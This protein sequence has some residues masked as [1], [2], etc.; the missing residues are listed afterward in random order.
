MKKLAFIISLIVGALLFALTIKEAGIDNVRNTILFFSAS[1]LIVVFLIN[2]LAI[3]V[4]G[5]MRWK[6]I[7]ESQNSHKIDFYKVL[8]AKL[9]GFAISYLTPSVLV[10]GEPI[11]AY[12]IKEESNY[13]WE[14]SFAS[15]IIDQAI[16]F[17][18]L[19]LFMIAGFLFLADHFSLPREMFY[20]FA[21]VILTTIFIFHLFHSRVINHNPDGDGLFMFI[22]KT[23][24]LNKF[25]FIKNREDNIRKT[26][27]IIAQF[28]KNKK[29]AFIKAFFLAILEAI[30]YLI[31]IWIIV[32]SLGQIVNLTKAI[33]IFFL[34]TVANFVPIPGSLGSFEA[35]LTFIF[36]LLELG[37][38]N[39]F[40][41]SLI[42]RF[43]NITLV[44]IGFF[45]L[46]HFELK[47]L[48]RDFS[49]EAPKSIQ[50]LHSF[51]IKMIYKK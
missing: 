36:N 42:Y 18:T 39:G 21:I 41:F 19:L 4:V 30:L 2:F 16:F 15:V 38:S 12:M 5:S 23:I 49:L 45:A 25:C 7:L 1:I 24:K 47:M 10:G 43:I 22:I 26:E 11:R 28:F 20:G 50:N 46:M 32:S 33:S 29:R 34:I 13:G 35:S 17:F 8:R 48:S 44:I 6:I 31:M 51:L 9:A 37:K 3:C 14:K 27:K 40:T